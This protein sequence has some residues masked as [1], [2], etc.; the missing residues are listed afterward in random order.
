M[1]QQLHPLTRLFILTW[2]LRA[3]A[4]LCCMACSL[5][6]FAQE[7]SSTVFYDEAGML[8]YRADAE[9]NYIPDFSH[10]GY[11]NG[12]VSLPEVPTV[13]TIQPVAGDNT[14]HIQAALD[15]LAAR[16][17]DANGYR[18]ALLLEAGTYDVAGQLFIR[19]SGMVLRGVGQDSSAA[20]NTII[21]GLG[22]NPDKRNLIVMGPVSGAPDWRAAV[23]GTESVVT[24]P[25]VPNGSR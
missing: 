11:R 23:P 16:T 5:G 14:A 19:E 17:P 9:N 25:F 15:E 2:H 3:V 1:Q 12:E 13:L 8:R 24:S 22:N 21:R 6:L 4:L 18:G 10:A 7:V 20:A